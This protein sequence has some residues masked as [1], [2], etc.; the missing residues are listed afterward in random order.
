MK[1][2]KNNHDFQW[3]LSTGPLKHTQKKNYI[4]LDKSHFSADFIADNRLSS[5]TSQLC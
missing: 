2:H 5:K 3:S 1:L 4:F